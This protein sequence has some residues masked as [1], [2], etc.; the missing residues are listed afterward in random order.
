MKGREYQI[1]HIER[2]IE[3]V[4][5][6]RK[7]LVQLPTG[8][9]KTVMFS[10]ITRRFIANYKK[11]V[12]I[13]VHRKELLSQAARTIEKITGMKPFLITAETKKYQYASIYISMVD[14]TIN[15]MHLMD[16]IGL[17]IIDECHIANFNKMHDV[18]LEEFI[19]GF[20]ATP[21]SSSKKQPMN[22]FYND[23][24][25]GVQISELIKDKFLSQVVTRMPE[26]AVD[27]KT[28]TI[29]KMTGDFDEKQLYSEFGKSKNVFNTF[30]AY[31]KFCN[32]E[33]T[34]I[35]N[36]NIEHSKQVTDLFQEMGV[37]CKHLDSDSHD[38]DEIL[39]WFK[40]TPGAVLCNVMIAT[41]GFDEPTIRNVI[42]NYDTLSISKYLQCGGRGGRIIDSKL[43]L[44]L[45]DYEKYNF[46]IIDM[47]ANALR[48]GCWSDDRDWEYIFNNPDI[49]G[50]GVAP[51]KSCPNCEGIVHAAATTCHLKMPDG[52]ECGYI[53]E[54]RKYSEDKFG[55]FIVVT[56]NVDIN[57]LVEKNIKKYDYYNF[58]KIIESF[59]EEMY[60]Q[61][62]KSSLSKMQ[63]AFSACYLL[64]CEWYEKQL[65]WKEDYI[66][67]IENS[68]WHINRCKNYF[69]GI[70]KNYPFDFY[71]ESIDKICHFCKSTNKEV[72]VSKYST[73]LVCEDCIERGF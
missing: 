35:F 11:S 29:N 62:R 39:H 67:T 71:E 50:E 63:K 46:N 3:A 28:M 12:L 73:D 9:G 69:Y 61:N 55:D 8:G 19:I 13:M 5:S 59:V 15:R 18:F 30:K 38:R 21:I 27:T 6:K 44:E 43:A 70:L 33:K 40:I 25:P 45:G 54:R 20:S 23:I 34:I 51:V 52:T 41:V 48:F 56:K 42:L 64:C 17:V 4:S 31:K 22:K 72:K 60:L 36:V 47:A 24:V 66:D 57:S 10:L 37:N 7:V 68:T 16:N 1:E 49:P 14:S 53:F 26:N 58:F 32:K 2:I 65:G